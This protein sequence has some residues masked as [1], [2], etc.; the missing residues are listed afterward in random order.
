[1][2]PPEPHSKLAPLHH[3]FQ[4][5]NQFFFGA[6]HLQEWM[7]E[8]VGGVW[9]QRDVDFQGRSQE[10]L[11]LLGERFGVFDLWR[12][13]RCNQVQSCVCTVSLKVTSWEGAEKGRGKGKGKGGKGN[14]R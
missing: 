3:C 12:S 6:G 10:G 1:M 8:E 9:P 5:R 7:L 2:L 4:Q 14:V 11:E 13:G